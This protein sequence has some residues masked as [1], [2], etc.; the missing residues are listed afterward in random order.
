MMFFRPI[1]PVFVALIWFSLSL[2]GHSQSDPNA[3]LDN[4]SLADLLDLNVSLASK[5]EEPVSEAPSIVAV[6][7]AQDIQNSGARNFEDILRMVPGFDLVLNPSASN[8]GI[9]VRGFLSTN[10]TNNQVKFLINGHHVH[11]IVGGGPHHYL[12]YL[13]VHNIARIEI[14]RGPGS[15]LYGANAFAAVIDIITK[16]AESPSEI[17]VEAGS[18]ET[19][20]PSLF[21]NKETGEWDIAL[22]ASQ[23][24]TD[25]PSEYVESDAATLIFGSDFSAA[26]GYTTQDAENL[27]LQAD[28]GYRGFKLTGLYNKLE[29]NYAIGVANALTDE[30]LLDIEAGYTELSYTLDIEG[31]KGEFN[32]R[33]Y[34]DFFNFGPKF[35]IFSEETATLFSNLFADRPPYPEGEGVLGQPGVDFYLF[36]GEVT[37]KYELRPAVQVLGGL[38]YDYSKIFNPTHVVNANVSGQPLTIGDRTYQPFEYIG[39]L[40]DIA[41]IPGGTWISLGNRTN[42]ASYVQARVDFKQLFEWGNRL[43]SFALTMGLRY[44][45]YSDIGSSTN[46]RVGLVFSPNS[47]IFIKGLYGEAFRAPTF[48]ELYQVNNPSFI[49]NPDL[50]PQKLRTTE[51]QLGSNYSDHWIATLSFFNTQIEDIIQLAPIA[52]PD[53]VGNEFQNLGEVHSQGVE[54]DAKYAFTSQRY[55]F[56]N[57]TYQTAENTT[58]EPIMVN[59]SNGDPIACQQPDY[60]VGNIP[61]AIFNAGF[62]LDLFGKLNWNATMNYTTSRER[63]GEV[64]AVNPS[65][66]SLQSQTNLLCQ[67]HYLVQIDQRPPTPSRLLLN[68]SLQWDVG[69]GFQLRFSGFN[70]LD[71]THLD[72]DS[73]GMIR[74][75]IPRDGVTYQIDARYRF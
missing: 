20:R 47:K 10:A 46:P 16:G 68:T 63:K 15:A 39:P 23:I 6:I 65:V 26:P 49:G 45:D 40:T 69:K 48:D 3:N 72:P 44:D 8:L 66:S 11:S 74:N 9:S 55:L 67:D 5:T 42:F 12:D 62:N 59:D 53:Q 50:R 31:G 4:L 75:D 33:T 73:S 51:V 32:F 14:I 29:K 19:F 22:S 35:E 70:L 13:P 18:H 57:Y 41:D 25:G 56:F 43:E 30:N 34:Y 54:V 38:L 60:D 71:D 37:A 28:V 17:A 21:W 36:G 24:T 7:T 52:S 58:N 2:A 64:M 27:T 61:R 1:R